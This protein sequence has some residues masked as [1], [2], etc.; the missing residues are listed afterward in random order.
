MQYGTPRSTAG[1][2]SFDTNIPFKEYIS[3]VSFLRVQWEPFE[4]RFGKVSSS[5]KHHRDVLS[6]SVQALQ[7]NAILDGN[8]DAEV[9]RERAKQR[10]AGMSYLTP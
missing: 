7:Y 6:H 8:H 3:I 4:T 1:F 9:E 2:T 5:F 10:D